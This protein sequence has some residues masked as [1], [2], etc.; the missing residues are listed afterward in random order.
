MTEKRLDNKTREDIAHNNNCQI[1]ST[2]YYNAITKFY[3]DI[4]YVEKIGESKLKIACRPNYD[5]EGVK[6]FIENELVIGVD[7]EIVVEETEKED[8]DIDKYVPDEFLEKI[9]HTRETFKDSEI[10]NL[11]ESMVLGMEDTIKGETQRLMKEHSLSY[12]EA[13]IIATE[14]VINSLKHNLGKEGKE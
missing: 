9:G 5:A 11:L 4:L 3:N 10:K 1:G 13:R 8:F 7:Y 2:V 14:R 6:E 12:G